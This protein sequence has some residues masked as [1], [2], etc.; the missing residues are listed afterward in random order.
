MEA[1]AD[2]FLMPSL[3]EPCGLNQMYSLAYGTLPLVRAVGGLKDTV[4]DWD[5]DPTH[6]TGFCFNDPTAST[7]LDAMRRSLLHYLQEPARFARVQHHA[8]NTRFDWADSVILYEQMY[9]DALATV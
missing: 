9:Q 2:L 8:M 3:F 5:A 4:V 1:G 7:L 6:A